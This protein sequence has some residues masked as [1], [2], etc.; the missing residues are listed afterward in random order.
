MTAND[1]PGFRET[2]E[3]IQQ[4]KSD[5]PNADY[6]V[7]ICF[8]KAHAGLEAKGPAEPLAAAARTGYANA[9]IERILRLIDR[10]QSPEFSHRLATDRYFATVAKLPEFQAMLAKARKPPG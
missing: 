9:C 2:I 5:D 4:I 8:G 6:E 7:A 3:A 1:E 10:D